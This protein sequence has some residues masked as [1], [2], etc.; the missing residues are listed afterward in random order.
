MNA[1]Y[2]SILE[3]LRAIEIVSVSTVEAFRSDRT[4][5][6]DAKE[7]TV[8]QFISKYLPSTFKVKKGII[9][10]Q[11]GE[12]NNIDCVVLAPNHP[13]LATPIRE[14]ILA[15]GVYAAIEVK[16]DISVLTDN[17]EFL[18]GLKQIKSVKRL[19][20]KTEKFDLLKLLNTDPKPDYF[21]KIPSVI[22][23]HKSSSIEKTLDFIRGKINEGVLEEHD[24]PDLIVMLDKGILYHVPYLNQSG[25][26]KKIPDASKM[27]FNNKAFFFFESPDKGMLLIMFL[28]LFLNFT[29]PVLMLHDFFIKDYLKQI[30]GEIKTRY[31][32]V[33]DLVKTLK[34]ILEKP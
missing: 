34:D 11:G 1:V 16:P 24:L 3:N 10:S 9:Y 13:E 7:L 31:F 8:D 25:L 20:R 15:E 33:E 4:N 22:F 26:S 21:K 2:G 5:T 30:D 19:D 12:S 29:S 28:M 14:V 32:P 6:G 18:R 27:L 17:G 23:S